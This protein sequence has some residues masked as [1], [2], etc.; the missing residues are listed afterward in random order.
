MKSI[1]EILLILEKNLK[2]PKFRIVGLCHLADSHDKDSIFYREDFDKISEEDHLNSEE[3]VKF[4]GFLRRSKRGQV[5][6]YN[7]GDYKTTDKKQFAWP[8]GQVQP[9]LKWI[10]HNIKKLQDNG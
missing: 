3:V 9:R 6:F 1:L 2:D 10:Q 7:S 8:M 5:W 4:K